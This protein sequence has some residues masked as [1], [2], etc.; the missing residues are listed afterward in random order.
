MNRAAGLAR[1]LT[2]FQGQTLN[3]SFSPDGR[4]VAFSGEYAGNIDV[5]TVPVDGG[6]PKR[7]TWHPGGDVVQGWMPDGKSIIF[8]SGRA[9]WA[10][11]A[12]TRFWT[13]PA[14]GGVESPMALPRAYQGKVSPQGPTWP[15][16][17][18]ARGMRSAAITA[19]AR[20]GRSGS[21]TSRRAFANG[22]SP[23]DLGHEERGRLLIADWRL[24]IAD[25]LIA[26]CRLRIG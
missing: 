18:I 26:D 4:T 17:S 16:A 22:A 9:T 21:S 24:A 20:T 12:T 15:I 8:A 7:L 3:P 23:T 13:V 14:D 2:S 25:W 1:R 11:N 5:Y 10:P 19:A 6:D